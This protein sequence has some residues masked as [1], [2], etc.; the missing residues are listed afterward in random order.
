M[1]NLKKVFLAA[2][3]LLGLAAPAQADFI[4]QSGNNPPKDAVEENIL[5]GT[6]FTGV[7]LLVGFTN[8]SNVAI[9][10]DLVPGYLGG[11]LGIGTNGVGQADIVC[12]LTFLCGSFDQNGANGLQLEDLEIKVQNGFGATDFIGNL[13]FGEGIFRVS[14]GDQFG[15]H[16]DYTLGNGQNFFTILAI[17]NEVIT[18]IRITGISADSDGH[19]GFNSFKQPRISGLCTLTGVNCQAI[20]IPEPSSLALFGAG[21]L[22]SLWFVSRRKSSIV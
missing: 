7:P 6:K 18:D 14:V 16:F 19:M 8:Q 2:G 12:N 9:T 5:F 17:N 13:D 20:D 22:A 11:Q 4:F 1:K 15:Q 3:L 10:F 21:L